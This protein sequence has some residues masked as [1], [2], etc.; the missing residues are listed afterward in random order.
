MEL[1]Q[2]RELARQWI[3]LLRPYSDRIEIAGSVRRCKVEV[4]DIEI[5]AAPKIEKAVR[6]IKAGLSFP[7]LP[8]PVQTIDLP[9]EFTVN[10]LLTALYAN[11][12]P[13]KKVK[14]GERYWQ[15]AM[16]EGINLDLFMVL[17]PAQW[18]IIYT[19]R[20]GP[21][22]FSHW[23]VTSK[24]FGGAL[25]SYARVSEGQLFQGEETVPM[26]E[27]I[28]FLNFL[29]LGWIEPGERQAQWRR[30]ERRAY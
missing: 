26:P 7:G 28:D 4:K 16:S 17:P 10:K 23:I 30:N 3:E 20:T 9:V 19:I 27:E 14:G 22:D 24:R 18:G 12:L 5:V 29:G 15:I 1:E 11:V 6:E 13:G 25:P 21:A 2:A 8:V